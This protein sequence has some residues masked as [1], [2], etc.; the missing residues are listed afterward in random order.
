MER[1]INLMKEKKKE[2]LLSEMYVMK[3]AINVFK[4]GPTNERYVL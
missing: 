2:K 3:R 4:K 1:A